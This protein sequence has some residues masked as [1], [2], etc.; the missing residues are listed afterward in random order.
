MA[1]WLRCPFCDLQFGALLLNAASIPDIAPLVCEGCGQVALL[2][3]G[4]PYQTTPEQLT[5]FKQSPAW[6]EVIAPA[7][8]IIRQ[9]LAAVTGVRDAL[10]EAQSNTA[11]QRKLELSENVPPVD[12]SQRVFTDGSPVT[13][14]YREIDPRTGQQKRYV[15]LSEAERAKGFVRPVR[16]TYRHVG[17][18]WPA[19][20]L[21]ELT[22]EEQSRYADVGYVRFESY[23]VTN[24]PG[25]AGRFWT[26][27]QLDCVG[28]GCG[29]E[30]TMGV[31]LAET[32]ARDP[33]FY[34]GTFCVFCKQHFPVNEFVWLGTQ[35]RVGT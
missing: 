24:G 26:Q 22:M 10:K 12:R 33:G 18:A 14:E 16:R 20:P 3:D 8:Q 23:E 5:A 2:I 1:E 21:R 35:K 4:Q 6:R 19:H 11:D 27:D 34:G 28:R 15:V 17:S 29:G 30:T 9:N 31:A 7:Q 32:Y 13:P 25:V